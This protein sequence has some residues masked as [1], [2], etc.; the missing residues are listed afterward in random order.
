M[1]AS[2]P[3]STNAS[4]ENRNVVV[5]LDESVVQAAL[6]K[7]CFQRSLNNVRERETFPRKA[8]YLV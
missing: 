2:V 4:C 1:Y 8:P 6:L 5:H 3:Q 7:R